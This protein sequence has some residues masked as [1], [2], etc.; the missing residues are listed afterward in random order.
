[1]IDAELTENYVIEKLLDFVSN[2]ILVNIITIK[3][4]GKNKPNADKINADIS[5]L[6]SKL[7]ELKNQESLYYNYLGDTQKLK[8]L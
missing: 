2:P 1:M 6:K 5:K 4:R 3:A 8:V 7:K